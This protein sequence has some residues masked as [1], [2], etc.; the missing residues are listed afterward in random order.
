MSVGLRLGALAFAWAFTAGAIEPVLTQHNN[1]ER[2]GAYLTETTLN[3]ANVNSSSFGKLFSRAVDDQIYAQPLYVPGLAIPGKGTRNVVFVATVADSVYAFDADDPAAH[4]PLWQVNLLRPGEAP[5][6]AA[7]ISAACGINYRDFSGNMGIV[8]TP[9][10]DPAAGILFVVARAKDASGHFVQRLHALHLETGLDRPNSP[11]VI[12]PSVPGT[13]DGG[14]T[15]TF[16]PLRQNQRAGLLLSSGTVYI[17]WAAHNDC[18]PFHGWVAGYD[19]DTLKPAS[20]YNVTANGSE[21]G[22][23]MSGQG[24]AAD[25]DGY[26][27]VSTGNGTTDATNL[28][29]SVIKLTPSLSVASSFTPY[30]FADLSANDLDLGS[31]GVLLV[32]GTSLAVAGGKTSVLYVVDRSNL[33][34]LNLGLSDSQIVQSIVIGA[35]HIHGSSVFW[36]GS[37]GEFLYVWTE[38]DHLKAYRFDRGAGQ[39]QVPYFAESPVAVPGGMPGAMLSL[40]SNGSAAGTGV[41]WA[42]HPLSGSA[43]HSVVPGILR[44]FDASD[45]THELWNSEQVS[46][47]DSVGRFAKFNPPTVANGRVYL[48]TFSNQLNVYGLLPPSIATQPTDQ[49]VAVGQPLTL[50]VTAMGQHVGYQWRRGGQ[51]V[52]GATSSTYTKSS[53]AL[54]DSGSY[55]VVVTNVGGSVS[56]S[57]AQVTVQERPLIVAQPASQALRAGQP[58]ALSVTATGSNLTYRWR[59]HGVPIIDAVHATYTKASVTS[60]D[61]DRYDVVVSNLAGSVT[62]TAAAVQVD[63]PAIAQRGCGCAS[64]GGP[65]PLS[66]LA[67]VGLLVLAM[68]ARRRRDARLGRRCVEGSRWTP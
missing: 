27:Y 31:G 55:D 9:V 59:K 44:A 16:D 46:A 23:W 50:S 22:I 25:S 66:N 65:A 62:S 36:G 6:N 10:I 11:A 67:T 45:V 56:S 30:N 13:G 39:F 53:A 34:G 20:I 12:S 1:N 32:P 17:T 57:P 26:V 15:V 7:D 4:D 41:L 19:A 14:T 38:E 48:A 64:G 40:S 24:P 58:L 43:I 51:P 63:E 42:V 8:G 21:G 54:S 68:G 61:S 49:Q 5:P 3:V 18:T 28:S 33:G 35:G 29:D 47:L 52:T 60:A 2:T 37:A